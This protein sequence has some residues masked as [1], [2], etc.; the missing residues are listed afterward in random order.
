MADTG[1]VPTAPDLVLPILE[2]GDMELEGVLPYS[3]NY[4]FL[5]TITL[6]GE[7]LRCVY[8]PRQGENPLGDFPY[9]TLCQR[10]TAAFVISEALG[11]GLVPPTCMRE[12]EHGPGSVQLFIPHDPD[13][14]YFTFRYQA[15]HAAALRRLTVF[16]WVVNN[17]DRKSGHCLIGEGP[18][19]WAIDHGICFHSLY[20]LRTVTWEF[21][22]QAIEPEH[23]ADLETCRDRVADPDSRTGRALEALLSAAE[24]EALVL[25]MERLLVNPRYPCHRRDRRNF[26]WP[27]I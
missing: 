5:A 11:W 25:R 19:V 20:K 21:A 10:E 4:S 3:S 1:A 17:A 2:Q 15:C 23:L 6:N 24:R 26:P 9:G 27:P 22:G 14:H 12:G 18:R 16:D 8:K 7:A 13:E